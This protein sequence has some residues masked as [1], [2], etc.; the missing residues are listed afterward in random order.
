MLDPGDVILGAAFLRGGSG[1]TGDGTGGTVIDTTLRIKGAAAD[2]A[3]TGERISQTETALAQKFA[4]IPL[5]SLS[6]EL[7]SLL[8]VDYLLPQRLEIGSVSTST[9]EDTVSASRIRARAAGFLSAE[10]CRLRME[11]DDQY[12]LGIQRIWYS[13]SADGTLRDYSTSWSAADWTSPYPDRLYKMIFRKGD[14][15]AITDEELEQIARSI[16]VVA[17]EAEQRVLAGYASL[18]DRLAGAEARLARLEREEGLPAYY[19]GYLEE[20]IA[21]I[22]AAL[23]AEGGAGKAAFFHI[24]DQ[25]F[26]GNAGWAAQLMRRINE[27]CGID[28]CVNTGDF[29]NEQPGDKAGALQL[30][31]SAS[32]ALYEANAVYLPVAGNHDDNCNAGHTDANRIRT[33]AIRSAE[34]YQYLYKTP[35]TRAGVTFGPTGRYYYW[36][37]TVRKIRYVV[38]DCCDGD[39]YA[40]LDEAAGTVQAKPYDVSPEQ[41]NWLIHRALDVPDGWTVL[42]FSHI[43]YSS[44]SYINTALET[45]WDLTRNVF[46]GFKNHTAGGWEKD[47]V[48]CRFDFTGSGAEF[49]GFFCG[50]IH[51]DAILTR[52]SY[53]VDAILCDSYSVCSPVRAVGGVEEQAFDVVIVDTAAH[54]VQTIRIGGGEDRSFSY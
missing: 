5:G 13:Y 41:L 47:G 34:Q 3:E 26:P 49:V 27:A 54:T 11:I 20:K 35:C 39:T 31:R 16:R 29:F 23:G 37:D 7:R 6:P 12:G 50:H 42:G 51:A 25:H 17:A 19:D 30:L 2:A 46:D 18:P 52:Q 10:P 9:G 45:T 1:G 33:D 24:S 38:T 28:V 32:R 21:S 40:V 48:D 8:S 53:T 44:N 14:N 36:D 15:T 22:R 4:S 43:P